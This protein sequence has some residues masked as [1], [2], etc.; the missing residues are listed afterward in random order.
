MV[1]CFCCF[2]CENYNICCRYKYR[3]TFNYSLFN[4]F[5]CVYEC[6]ECFLKKDN[7]THLNNEDSCI[8]C[9]FL[10]FMLILLPITFVIDIITYPFRYYYSFYTYCECKRI[11]IQQK[12]TNHNII[13][14]RPPSYNQHYGH[15][16]VIQEIII[17]PPQYQL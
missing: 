17:V 9:E 15:S 2:Y 3:N 10:C 6:M 1:Q 16:R 11:K 14:D 5:K 8:C 13:I 12:N 7:D 4:D